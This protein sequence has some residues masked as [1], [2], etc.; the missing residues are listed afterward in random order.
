MELAAEARRRALACFVFLIR[1]IV[2]EQGVKRRRT[3]LRRRQAGQLKGLAEPFV[4][5][6]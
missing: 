2:K 4:D 1:Q 6:D 5:V 3:D